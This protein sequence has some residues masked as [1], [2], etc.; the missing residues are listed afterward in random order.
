MQPGQPCTACQ[1]WQDIEKLFHDH[2]NAKYLQLK[3]S[4]NQVTKGSLSMAEY[5]QHIKSTTDSLHSIGRPVDDDD[6]IL[7]I[8]SGLP[9]EYSDV[10]TIMIARKP[11]RIF[12]EL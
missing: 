5:L 11:L 9:Y 7:K 8:L 4:F 6:I 12:L 2:V 1:T 10:V 3:L